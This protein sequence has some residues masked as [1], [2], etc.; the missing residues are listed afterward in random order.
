MYPI[1]CPRCQSN[2]TSERKHGSALGYRRFSCRSCHRRFNERTGTPLAIS[3]S[4]PN[5]PVGNPLAPPLQLGLRDVA[6][7]LGQRGNEV[8]HETIR[9]WEFRFAPLV[10]A[11]LRAKSRG[12]PTAPTTW[13]RR[14]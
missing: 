10:S 9:V 4:P 1:D 8:T 2:A 6:E 11:S 5:H 12:Q 13:M 14:T 3:N 7:A